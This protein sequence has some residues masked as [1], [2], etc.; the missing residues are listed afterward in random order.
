MS[1][2]PVQIDYE[3]LRETLQA[4]KVVDAELAKD[5]LV[6]M[7][8]SGEVIAVDARHRFVAYGHTEWFERSADSFESRAR[9][10]G[11]AQALV[12]VGQRRRSSRE[13]L[14]RRPNYG[15]LQVK[16][17]L[18]PARTAHIAEAA[19]ILEATVGATLHRHGF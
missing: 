10:F 15:G 16:H 17:A 14:K 12:V 5:V 4:L 11:S 3:G 1:D 18:L 8:A 13:Q 2:L 7:A 19:E 6:G 9:P